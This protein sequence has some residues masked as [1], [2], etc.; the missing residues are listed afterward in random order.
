MKPLYYSVC[1]WRIGSRAMC[2]KTQELHGGLEQ[3]G[4][5]LCTTFGSY[6]LWCSKFGNLIE[7]KDSD[8]SFSSSVSNGDRFHP[9]CESFDASQKVSMSM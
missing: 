3:G 4:F 5:E 8:D 6:S 9:S 7:K 2:L 1:C